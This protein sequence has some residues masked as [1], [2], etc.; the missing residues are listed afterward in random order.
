[1]AGKWNDVAKRLAPGVVSAGLVLLAAAI[2]F[3]S[4][5]FGGAGTLLKVDF[6]DV[7]TVGDGTEAGLDSQ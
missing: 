3:R 1:M 6:R 7:A 5:A 2:I 4:L